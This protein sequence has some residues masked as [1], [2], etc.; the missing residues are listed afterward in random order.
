MENKDRKHVV[1]IGSGIG[2]SAIAA[3]LASRG[4]RV[5]VLEKLAFTGGRCCS[6]KRDGFILDLGVH[7]FSQAG[8]GPLGEVLRLCGR[9][10][11]A[12]IQWS[13]TRKPT[14]KLFYG[15]QCIEY[16]KGVAALGVNI[17]DFR[18]LMNKV[19]SMPMDR[20]LSLNGTSVKEW[21]A[22]QTS[23]PVIHDIFA[24]IT[25]LYFVTAYSVASAGEF[26][27]SM[28]AQALKRSSG[29]PIGGCQKIPD[30]YLNVVTDKG[31]SVRTRAGVER[32]V[33]E[34]GKA[35]GVVLQNGERLD[36]DIVISNVDATRTVLEMAGEEHFPR[37]Y[38]KRIENVSFA[39]GAYL[40]KFA[41]SRRI[42]EE[43]FIMSIA[44][45]NATEYYARIDN[46]EIPEKVNLMI[47]IISNLD[48]S[49]APEGQQLIIAGSLM[50][51][52]PDWEKW[53]RSVIHSLRDIFPDIEEGLLFT[54]D[55]SPR[56]VEKLMGEQGSVVGFA[57]TVDQVGEKRISQVTPVENLYLVGAEAGGWGIG[58]ELAANSAME[59]NQII[60]CETN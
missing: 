1:V 11:E 3:L 42:T 46:G 45:Q 56:E 52:N 23:D 47:P 33:I 57:Q 36:T 17:E 55:T 44:H 40:I 59:L 43:K 25:E 58:T 54:E 37:E 18:N 26:V 29:Y 48:P 38:L 34:N 16:P 30:S 13:Y 49:V 41:L 39:A 21:L 10:P 60:A 7:T 20:I 15:G 19:V 24:Y 31:E 8:A 51:R 9:D 5:T 2:G 4:Y 50:A 12:T 6:R 27:R 28:Q 22:E 53:H 35:V 32:I 14:Q